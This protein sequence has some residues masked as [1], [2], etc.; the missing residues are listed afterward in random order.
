LIASIISIY[1][2]LDKMP[3][4]QIEEFKSEFTR[5]FMKRKLACK[6]IQNNQEQTNFID[7]YKIL[8]VYA[9]KVVHK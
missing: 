6:T 5:E 1:P 4:D 9:E 8:I 3:H 2:F 7:L